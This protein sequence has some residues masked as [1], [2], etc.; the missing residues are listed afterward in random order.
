MDNANTPPMRNW[1][2]SYLYTFAF[3]SKY[4]SWNPKIR[5][6]CG[7]PVDHSFCFDTDEIRYACEREGE[8]LLENLVNRWFGLSRN[9]L[10]LYEDASFKNRWI[11]SF[12]YLTIVNYATK[13]RSSKDLALKIIW[14]KFYPFSLSNIMT[15]MRFNKRASR[16]LFY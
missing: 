2:I 16:N 3:K 12:L 7:S 15:E 6:I 8:T 5:Q 4:G 10:R 9:I 11:L 14:G 13:K 1:E